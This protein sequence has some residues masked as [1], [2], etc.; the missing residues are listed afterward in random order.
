MKAD[1]VVLDTNILVTL[2]INK[3]LDELV[4][5]YKDRHITIYICQ[6][7]IDELSMVLKRPKIKRYLS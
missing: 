4:E 1:R 7:L 3:Q 5:W 6:E 2:I